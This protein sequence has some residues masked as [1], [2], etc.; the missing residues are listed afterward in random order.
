MIYLTRTDY[1]RQGNAHTAIA[2]CESDGTVAR[3]EREGYT[4]CTRAAY[5]AAWR[6]NDWLAMVRLAGRLVT[7]PLSRA[8][9]LE[10]HWI[11]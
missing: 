1:D 9:G 11:R 2:A 8:V 4:R 6:D 7:A 10:K 3:A 5:M